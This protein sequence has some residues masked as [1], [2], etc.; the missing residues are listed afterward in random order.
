MLLKIYFTKIQR[1]DFL[2][3]LII[4]HKLQYNSSIMNEKTLFFKKKK[5]IEKKQNS[6]HGT[7]RVHRHFVSITRIMNSSNYVKMEKIFSFSIFYIECYDKRL[8]YVTCYV[9]V[10]IGPVY[11]GIVYFLNV[12]F[13]YRRT[14]D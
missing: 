12:L 6:L 1:K 7:I 10:I 5:I 2:R 9:R 14:C 8:F 4:S 11:N 13:I 3:S